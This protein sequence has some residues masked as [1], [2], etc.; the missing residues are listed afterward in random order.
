MLPVVMVLMVSE[1]TDP[2]GSNVKGRMA[3]VV[4]IA[5]SGGYQGRNE[6]IV[7]ESVAV[8]TAIVPWTNEIRARLLLTVISN[9]SRY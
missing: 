3:E 9:A 4:G 7:N 8:F 1:W 6:R 5:D 2:T